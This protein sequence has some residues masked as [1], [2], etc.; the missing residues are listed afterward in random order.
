MAAPDGYTRYMMCPTFLKGSLS[1]TR[2]QLGKCLDGL[3]PDQYASAPLA[4]MMTPVQTM[5]HLCEAYTA[6]EA[7]LLKK[8]H[9][10]GSYSSGISDPEQLKTHMFALRDR[11]TQM[12]CES[13]DEQAYA[14]AEDYMVQHDAYHVGQLCA[15]RIATDPEFNPYSIYQGH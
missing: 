8:S 15:C 4:S 6:L 10:W 3:T 9:E 2:Y 5:E 7:A 12:V 11:I 14:M 13:Q 1:N